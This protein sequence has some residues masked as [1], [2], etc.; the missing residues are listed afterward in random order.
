MAVSSGA[1]TCALQDFGWGQ[2]DI[3]K[4]V[5]TLKKK[6]FFKT[7]PCQVVPGEMV[8]YY[9]ARKLMGEKVYIHLYI[10]IGTDMVVV[11]SCKQLEE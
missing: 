5:L 1:K 9:K 8:D 2:Q 11:Q 6:H 7:Q 3:I 10:D 4:A